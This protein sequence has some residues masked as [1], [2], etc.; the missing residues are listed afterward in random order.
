MWCHLF[1]TRGGRTKTTTSKRIFLLMY[2]VKTVYL[3][4]QYFI[5]DALVVIN[6][7]ALQL[8]S[9]YNFGEKF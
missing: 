5:T 4:I 9:A 6:F 3:Y 2:H 1:V 7:T 8:F